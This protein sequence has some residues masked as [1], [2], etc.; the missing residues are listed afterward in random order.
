MVVKNYVMNKYINIITKGKT[1]FKYRF[2]TEKEFIERFGNCWKD[3][4]ERTW[5]NEMNVYLGET[6]DE[7]IE[8]GEYYKGMH[9]F[10]HGWHISYDM[11]TKNEILTF[12]T[13]YAKQIL[14]YE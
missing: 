6:V 2:R 12:S 9:L 10:Y 13:I 8:E 4:V 7:E 14:C 3:D 1:K 5:S 11:L